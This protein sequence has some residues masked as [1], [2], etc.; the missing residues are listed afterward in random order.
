MEGIIDRRVE[1]D[2]RRRV[3]GVFHR[4]ENLLVETEE[5]FI[6]DSGSDDLF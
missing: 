3:E 4:G 6:N 2:F 1:G 5:S